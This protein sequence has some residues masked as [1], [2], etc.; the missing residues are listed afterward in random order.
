[1]DMPALG[2]IEFGLCWGTLHQATLPQLIDAAARHGFATLSFP[3]YL[4][5]DWLGAGYSSQMLLRKM[6]NAG[7]RLTVA[8][9]ISAG[10]PGMPETPISFRGKSLPRPGEAECFAMAEALEAPLV[11][12]SHFGAGPV[13]HE[14]LTEAVGTICRRAGA[15]GLG[16][17]LEF[18]PDTG[19]ADLAT[20]QAIA[21]G[22]GEANCSILLDSWHLARTGGTAADIRALPPGSIGA[23]QLSD[24]NP[25]AAGEV[26]VPMTGRL[27]P[28]EGSLPLH[29]I[30]G[31][32]L[33]NRPGLSAELE[34]FSAELSALPVDK[35]AA[36]AAAA[37]ASW[38]NG[39]VA[40]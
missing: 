39:P 27:L 33:A 26:Y 30:V 16:I 10:L 31:A 3:P 35:A 1:M 8:D 14:E 20:A 4:Y 15:R 18:V 29:D 13:S 24:R 36:R 38:R 37:L 2:E 17:V 6:R 9:C 40:S 19:I 7:V 11:N 32:A 5:A 23:I 21:T 25:P 28:G 22:C 34:V 12:I